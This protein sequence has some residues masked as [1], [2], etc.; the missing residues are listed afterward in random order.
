MNAARTAFAVAAREQLAI[1]ESMHDTFSQTLSGAVL[2]ANLMVRR[3]KAGGNV[4]VAEMN[5]LSQTLDRALG[6]IRELSHELAPVSDGPGGLM[7]A[8]AA[9][10][11]CVSRRGTQCSFQ[12]EEPILITN[13]QSA[14][15]MYRITQELVQKATERVD[16]SRIAVS[17]LGDEE[18]ISVRIADDG[19]LASGWPQNAPASLQFRAAA[20]GVAI[21][22]HYHPND[23]NVIECSLASA[24]AD[25]ECGSPRW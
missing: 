13:R 19:K 22:T 16:V 25:L 12:C 8:L 24:L 15:T 23:G 5:E 4:D 10:A 21:S 17:L 11:E 6:E 3:L 9:L 7:D 18:G 1:G 2:M 20:F 14:L